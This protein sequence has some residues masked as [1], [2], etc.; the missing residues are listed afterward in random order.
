MN[1]R[2]ILKLSTA[3][4][5]FPCEM[6]ACRDS[7]LSET[8]FT[9]ECFRAVGEDCRVWLGTVKA[10]PGVS[11]ERIQRAICEVLRNQGPDRLSIF[12]FRNKTI[13]S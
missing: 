12:L 5:S 6:F 11:S 7:N 3:I 4:A 9:Q 1:R 13:R 8:S 2:D 10:E